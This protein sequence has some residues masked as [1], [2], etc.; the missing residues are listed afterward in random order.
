MKAATFMPLLLLQK[1]ACKSKATDHITCLE[2]QLSAWVEGDLNELLMEGRTIQEPIPGWCPSH[3]NWWYSQ[4][5]HCQSQ[6]AVHNIQ[7]LCLSLTTA[8]ITTYRAP[9]ELYADGDVLLSQEGTTQGDPLAM[10]MYVLYI[11]SYH[12]PDQETEEQHERCLWCWRNQQTGMVGSINIEGPKS[13]TQA[14]PSLSPRRG[15]SQI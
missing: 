13:P 1:P 15:T 14:K 3:R 8:L 6:T 10:P 7:R 9:S 5:H 2:R 11:A 12:P 4:T